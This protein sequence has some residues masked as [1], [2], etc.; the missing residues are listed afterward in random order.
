MQFKNDPLSKG[1]ITG[2][3]PRPSKSTSPTLFVL[4]SKKH[5]SII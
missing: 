1:E 2:L 5:F 4:R 3:T